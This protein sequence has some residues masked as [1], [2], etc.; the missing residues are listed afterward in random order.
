MNR[1]KQLLIIFLL[2]GLT[3][4]TAWGQIIKLNRGRL[5][6]SFHHAQESSP[7]ADWQKM[8]E[9]L[10]W[11]GFEPTELN[12]NLGG[13]YSHLVAGGI[14]LTAL[15]PLRDASNNTYFD[16]DSVLGWMDFALNGDRNTSKELGQQPFI[17]REHKKI[18]PRGENYWGLTNP[19]EAE[20]LIYSY[21]EKDPQYDDSKTGNKKF[22]VSIKREVRQWSGSAADQDYVIVRYVIKS[23]ASERRVGID[24]AYV[25][26]TYAISPNN[27]GWTYSYPSYR[28]GARNTMSR[29]D[30]EEKL[31]TAWAGNF[32]N[33]PNIDDTYDPY[34]YYRY[35]AIDNVQRPVTEFMAPGI[36]GIKLLEVTPDHGPEPDKI[37][38]FTWSAGP[39]DSDYEGPFTAIAGMKNK[40]DAMKDVSRLFDAYTDTNDIRMGSQRLYANWS[41]G[42]YNLRGGGRDSIVIVV[43][44]FVGGLPYG[45]TFIDTIDQDLRSEKVREIREAADSAANYLSERLTFN[46]NHDFTVPLP[47]PAPPFTIEP[48]TAGGSVANVLLFDDSVE[49]IPDPQQNVIDIAGYRIYKSKQYPFGPWEK[50]ADIAIKDPS[51]WDDIDQVY[52]FKDSRVAL[53]Y[54]Y[55]YAVTAYDTGHDSWV[56][57]PSVSVPELESSLFANRTRHPFYSTLV[58]VTESKGA[59]DNVAV[60]PNPFYVTSGFERGGD[61]KN[62]QFV[63]L[64]SPCTIRIFTVKGNL[65]KVIEHNDPSSG[66]AF[67]NQISENKQYIK[68][69]LY[70]YHI[71]D[72]N[73]NTTRGK[74]AIIN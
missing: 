65:V 2:T 60:V 9:G 32:K 70:F 63:N 28:S 68:S 11:P 8:S 47:P 64:P 35:S 55:Y 13:T 61:L 33:T 36:V 51:Y 7:L 16:S 6:H 39:P 41:F 5:W 44:Q 66:V 54:G 22:N 37:N 10:D 53:G 73:G 40:Y 46:Y 18:W 58:P 14:Y 71:E 31:L 62:I 34:E 56:A 42:P 50:I 25:L 27:R 3:T 48:D 24:S 67:W 49:S 74:F 57:D 45:K 12:E 43:G 20:E 19:Y 15:K 72:S 69:G 1:L 30:P 59:L 52:K 23:L 38:G 17:S 26:L 4:N 29:W 21:I